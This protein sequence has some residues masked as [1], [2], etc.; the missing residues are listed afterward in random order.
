MQMNNN[1]NQF[2]PISTFQNMLGMGVNPQQIEQLIFMQN[3]QLQILANQMKQ[4]GLSP[5]DFVIQFARQNNMPCNPN[6]I[7]QMANQMRGMIP[8]R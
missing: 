6:V 2:N 5:V 3:P 7:N 8:Q 4:S 1:N